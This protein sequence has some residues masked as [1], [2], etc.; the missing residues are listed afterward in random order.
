MQMRNLFRQVQPSFLVA[1]G[2]SVFLVELIK[3]LDLPEDTE[4]SKFKVTNSKPAN[5]NA[6]NIAFYQ[7]NRGIQSSI[8]SARIFNL[9]LPGLPS[10]ASKNDR[11]LFVGSVIAM[12]QELVI[13]ALGNLLKYLHENRIKWRH[14]FMNLNQNPIITNVISFNTESQVLIDE[15]TFNSLN[16]FSHIYHPSSFK[17]QVRRDG[18]SLFNLVNQCCSTLGVLELKSMLKQPVRDITEL[19]FRFDSI[20]WLLKPEN[21]ENVVALRG[22]LKNLLNI[23]NIMSRITKTFGACGDWKSLKKTIYFCLLICELCAGFSEDSRRSTIIEPLASFIKNENTINGILFSLDKI[24]DLEGV[25]QKN[26]FCVKEGLDKALDE[27]RERLEEFVNHWSQ[28]IAPVEELSKPNVTLTDF[29]YV[30]FPEMGFVVGVAKENE[31]ADSSIQKGEGVEMILQTL[32]SIFFRTASCKR[33]NGEFEQKK[34]EIIQ[35]EMRIFDRFIKYINSSL[36]EIIDITKLCAK[37]DALISFASVSRQFNFTRPTITTSKELVIHKGRHPLVSTLTEYVPSTTIINET[38]K[39]YINIINAPNASGKSVYMKQVALI[40]YMAHIGMFVPAE[41]CSMSLLDSIYTRVYTPESL[42]QAESAFMADLQQMSKV[43]MNSSSRSLILV[44]EFGK[45]SAYKDGIALLSASI[46]HFVGRGELTPIAFIT[47]HYKQVWNLI[48][49]KER[50]NFKTIKT[51]QNSEGIFES[52]F[53][54]T[55]GKSDQNFA[56]EFPESSKIMKN[57]LV[58]NIR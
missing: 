56:T 44:D 19:N 13:I 16:I 28:E 29:N 54:I 5:A 48:R 57:I 31:D 52:L 17:T 49:C 34:A 50:T 22:H 24:V 21:F 51:Q 42:Y 8:Y 33:L 27:K 32:E 40:C 20:E 25:E 14:V 30:Y 11:K 35:H 4:I 18:L 23:S 1:A 7:F 9:D 55:D 46:E 43:V 3:L 36:A 41:S 15:N 58:P 10:E 39:N 38:N 26:R 45:G 47:T 6:S 2:P 12:D 37:L 53:E